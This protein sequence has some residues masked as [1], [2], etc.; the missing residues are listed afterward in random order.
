M[1]DY[2]YIDNIDF[3]QMIQRIYPAVLSWTKQINYSDIEAPFLDLNLSISK[4]RL[5]T[6]IW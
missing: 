1:D 2:L 3:E 5:S 4:G 6:N